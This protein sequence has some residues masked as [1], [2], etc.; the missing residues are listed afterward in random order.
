MFIL[1]NMLLAQLA[2]FVTIQYIKAFFMNTLYAQ[3]AL[4]PVCF[5]LMYVCYTPILNN[6]IFAAV[7]L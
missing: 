1:I 4:S 5:I 6:L 7:D 3:D 2:E